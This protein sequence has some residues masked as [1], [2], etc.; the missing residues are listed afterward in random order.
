MADFGRANGL[1][2]A[3]HAVDEVTHVIIGVVE[4]RR[5]TRQ[6]FFQQ[7][8]VTGR[9]RAAIDEDPLAALAD[10]KHAVIVSLRPISAVS[11]PDRGTLRIRRS[12]PLRR[13]TDQPRAIGISVGDLEVWM[14]VVA[15]R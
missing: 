2:T 3:A 14:A 11:S 5:I 4:P 8:R 7:F 15:V 6:L 13:T 12:L 10:E 1:L 9:D